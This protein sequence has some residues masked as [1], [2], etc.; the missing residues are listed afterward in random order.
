SAPRLLAV[1]IFFTAA[2]AMG[3]GVLGFETV[4]PE[5]TA[6]ISAPLL[7]NATSVGVPG[8]DA[9][10]A[11]DG[12]SGGVVA[13]S[14]T[15]LPIGIVSGH[16]GSDSGAVCDG[17][18]YEVDVNLRIAELVVGQ[19]QDLGYT[20]DLLEE[21]D[22]RLTGYRALALVSIHA[23]SCLY[24]EATGFK[25]AHVVDSAVPELEDLLVDCLT[26]R[27]GARTGLAFHEG[28]ITPDMLYYHNFYEIDP[29]TPG[30]IIEVGFML[31]DRDIL[32]TQPELVAQGIVD[33]IEC[34]L[35]QTGH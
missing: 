21:F 15:P 7:S 9:T 26:D 22:E 10:P 16:W 18:L 34:F 24:P 3:R 17:D 19:L 14:P 11:D 6:T 8:V 25:V 13:T 2:I 32:L 5:G 1:V 4:P 31:A 33:G 20:V 12:A 23:D 30:A 28:S 29:E 35:E 27:Y